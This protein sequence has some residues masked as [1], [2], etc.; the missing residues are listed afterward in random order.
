MMVQFLF[1]I[2]TQNIV[3]TSHTK[4]SFNYKKIIFSFS[5]L[6]LS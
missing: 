5:L 1:I 2:R 6:G 4:V 3:C